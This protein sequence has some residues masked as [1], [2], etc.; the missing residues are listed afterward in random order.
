MMLSATDLQRKQALRKEFLTQRRQ[1]VQSQRQKLS[2]IYQDVASQ[3]ALILGQPQ[4]MAATYSALPDEMNPR[5]LPSQKPQW[6]FA[7]PRVEGTDLR[8]YVP[9]TASDFAVGGM[10]IRE[11]VPARSQA[12]ELNDCAA[13]LVPGVAFDRRGGR[14]GYGKGFY[15]RALART[16]ALKIGIGF[17]VQ[18]STEDLPIAATDV[19]MDWIV[20]ENFTFQTQG[21]ASA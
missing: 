11:P 17:T 13:V 14:L 3:L 1:Y 15:D 10:G 20:T 12:I 18:I 2:E 19:R 5:D 6:R 21:S 4:G 8:F 16:R 9:Q 7:Y